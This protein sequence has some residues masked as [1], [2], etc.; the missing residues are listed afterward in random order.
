MGH[1]YALLVG[2]YDILILSPTKTTWHPLQ[3]TPWTEE[4][5]KLESM[6]PQGV[7]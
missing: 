6:G 4:P 7:R 3:R 2:K 1:T 5:G